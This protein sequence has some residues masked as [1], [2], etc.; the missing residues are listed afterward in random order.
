MLASQTYNTKHN[1]K[2]S[3]PIRPGASP[4]DHPSFQPFMQN[5]K[6]RELRFKVY[7][8]F[9][10]RAASDETDNTKLITEI[11]TL[12]NESAKLLGYK[13]YAE[14]SLDTKM[15]KHQKSLSNV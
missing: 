5:C 12:R 10:N 3:L 7:N 8:A 13:N 4:W 11:L 15:A 14:F 2:E 6:N 1:S 9:V